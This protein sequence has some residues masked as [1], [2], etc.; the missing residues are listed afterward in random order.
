MGLI[1]I[2]KK[3]ILKNFLLDALFTST[4]FIILTIGAVWI[5]TDDFDSPNTRVIKVIVPFCYTIILLYSIPR[6]LRVLRALLDIILNKLI[7][8][9]FTIIDRDKDI[10]YDDL[11]KNTYTILTTIDSR[12]RRKK[13][14]VDESISLLNY[15][16]KNKVIIEYFKF[17]GVVTSIER[18]PK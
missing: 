3:K 17:S 15:H 8:N 7:K 4:I 12:G 13:F 6:V 16:K 11:K 10:G 5:Y 14:I 18:A 9:T 1:Y 2:M